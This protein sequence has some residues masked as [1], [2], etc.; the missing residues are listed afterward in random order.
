MQNSEIQYVHTIDESDY[1][2]LRNSV[3]WPQ[4]SARQAAASI[5]N[6]VFLIAARHGDKTIGMTRVVS[7]GGYIMHIADV[8]VLPEYQRQ[9]IGK[10]MVGM[11]MQ[12]IRGTIHEGETVFVNLMAA[13]GKEPFY[14]QF[15]F[16]V[17]PN[18][19]YGAGMSQHIKK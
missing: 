12:Y 14:R 3:Q 15:G 10:T 4:L 11:A 16:E 1:L 9:G 8:V 2:F 7:D 13:K 6:V 18:D 17:R 19:K 5:K